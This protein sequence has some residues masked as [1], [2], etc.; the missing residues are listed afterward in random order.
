MPVYYEIFV[1][2]GNK[3]GHTI[4]IHACD[5]LQKANDT[6]LRLFNQ[7]VTVSAEIYDTPDENV[8]ETCGTKSFSLKEIVLDGKLFGT[9]VVK[10]T[11]SRNDLSSLLHRILT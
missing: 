9:F 4:F 5:D 10:T 1:R 2:F 11:M 7:V 6:A 3:E 8:C